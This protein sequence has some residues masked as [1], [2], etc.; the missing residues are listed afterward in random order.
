LRKAG[1][2]DLFAIVKQIVDAKA[3]FRSLAEPWADT[4]TGRLMIAVLGG[5][6][7]VERDLIRTRTA[8]G[9]WRQAWPQTEAHPA[10]A[11]RSTAAA[12]GGRNPQRTG[13]ELQRR[14]RDD[15]AAR[16]LKMRPVVLLALLAHI[17]TTPRGMAM[18]FRLVDH[19]IYAAGAIGEGDANKLAQLVRDKG[20]ESGFDDFTVRLNSP[21]GLL[22]EGIKI[23]NVIR[24]AELETLVSRGDECASACALA[25]LAAQ[26]DTQQAPALGVGWSL[27]PHLVFTDSVPPQTH[28]VWRVRL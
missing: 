3:Q 13:E 16:N 23:G 18:D 22:L 4:G 14:P 25:F 19:T 20:L 11:E 8:E 27:V 26:G 6:A 2:F 21:G 28:F 5:L 15:L 1:T 12:S 7:G 10:A 24:D 17:L 9:A